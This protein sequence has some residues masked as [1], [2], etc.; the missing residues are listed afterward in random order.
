MSNFLNRNFNEQHPVKKALTLH[1]VNIT[2]GHIGCE[3]ESRQWENA[4]SRG[5]LVLVSNIA[6]MLLVQVEV[7]LHQHLISK[8]PTKLRQVTAKIMDDDRYT[9]Y[10]VDNLCGLEGRGSTTDTSQEC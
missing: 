6:Y 10:L 1:L 7:V 4:I 8:K 2:E 5:S 9:I 3:D